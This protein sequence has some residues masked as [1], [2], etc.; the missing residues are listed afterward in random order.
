[1]TISSPINPCLLVMLRH[2]IWS[3][4]PGAM[5]LAEDWNLGPG[6][7]VQGECDLLGDCQWFSSV[8]TVEHHWG[9]QTTGNPRWF[10]SLICTSG[11]NHHVS[12]GKPSNQHNKPSPG[13][14]LGMRFQPCRFMAGCPHQFVFRRGA[15][16]FVC[17]PLENDQ[18]FLK[19]MMVFCWN[20]DNQAAQA[21]RPRSFLHGNSNPKPVQSEVRML[22]LLCNSSRFNLTDDRWRELKF[23]P[24]FKTS[25]SRNPIRSPCDSKGEDSYDQSSLK[26]FWSHG[27][28]LLLV[29]Y[30]NRCFTHPQNCW[31]LRALP[32]QDLDDYLSLS[33]KWSYHI[34]ENLMADPYFPDSNCHK[35]YIGALSDKPIYTRYIYIIIINI[36]IYI[37]WICTYIYNMNQN[38]W[39]P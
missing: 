4:W 20:L 2:G 19:L 18:T 12:C 25:R 32:K 11:F 33:K 36:Y 35:W 24:S 37:I 10:E 13:D 34:S 5:T 21:A 3:L 28:S 8:K 16:F 29:N 23:V 39:P 38:C 6:N 30:Q 26:A 9:F 31:T 1:M 14:D 17:F 22:R 15:R 27:C 7:S